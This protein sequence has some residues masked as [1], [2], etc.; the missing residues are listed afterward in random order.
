MS[1][2]RNPLQKLYLP[3]PFN[4]FIMK[5][6]LNAQRTIF[7]LGKHY[8]YFLPFWISKY[9]FPLKPKITEIHKSTFWWSNAIYI[10]VKTFWNM[11]L[12]FHMFSSCGT[13]FHLVCTALVLSIISIFESCL[14]RAEGF[15]YGPDVLHLPTFKMTNR[16]YVK[17]FTAYSKCWWHP[18]MYKQWNYFVLKLV[19]F[20]FCHLLA[21]LAGSW[22]LQ[23]F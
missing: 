13:K 9:F 21:Y 17:V 14:P 10:R 4:A 23:L 2:G 7:L 1:C 18:F 6:H 8:Y 19:K 12:L 15:P 3:R 22:Y 11:F 16:V 5:C 20:I